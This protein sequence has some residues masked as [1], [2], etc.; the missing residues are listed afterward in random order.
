MMETVK[1]VMSNLG[2]V[3]ADLADFA[4]IFGGNTADLAKRLSGNTADLA[5][6]AA[7]GAADLA[8]RIG[9]RRL[10]GLAVVAGAVVGGIYLSR[11]LKA[12]A[13]AAAN[14]EV[15]GET[16]AQRNRKRSRARNAAAAAIH[17]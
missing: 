8:E 10:I 11:Y 12:R 5:K 9:T 3:S 16:P 6:S 4:R 15:I 14:E 13:L 17:H 2:D 7:D 1:H